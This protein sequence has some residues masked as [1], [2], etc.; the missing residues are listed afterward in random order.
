MIQANKNLTKRHIA[1]NYFKFLMSR[2]V[3]TVVDTGVLWILSTHIFKSN[4]G[5]YFISPTISFEFAVVS[6]FFFSYFWIWRKRISAKSIKTF[7][8]RF[9]AFNLASI[10]G[11]VIKMSLLLLLARMFGWNVVYCNIVALLISGI[12][13]FILTEFA[14]FRKKPQI[15]DT[16]NDME[17]LENIN[18]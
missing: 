16:V 7:F 1:I 9:I 3:G 8:T 6:N 11:F 15:I 5:I 14:V 2:V 17:E 4:V 10:I 12:I 18:Y 13:N